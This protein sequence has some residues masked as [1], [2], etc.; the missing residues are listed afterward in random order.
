M[1]SLFKVWIV[2]QDIPYDFAI[3]PELK[4]E[5]MNCWIEI[6]IFSIFP[7]LLK[8]WMYPL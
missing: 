5:G 2:N 4:S 1:K 8:F 7:Q 3:L 6:G